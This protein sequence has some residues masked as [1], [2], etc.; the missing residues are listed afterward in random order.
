MLDYVIIIAALLFI[1]VLV[2]MAVM[3]L[4][5]I[6]EKLSSKNAKKRTRQEAEKILSEAEK[7]LR[8][9]EQRKE[10]FLRN[11]QLRDEELLRYLKQQKKNAN[12]TNHLS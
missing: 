5:W 2:Y 11:Q 8:D 9:H 1:G 10:I 4:F 3:V 6:Y 7:L 12:E